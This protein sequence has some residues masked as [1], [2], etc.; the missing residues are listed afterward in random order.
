L[1]LVALLA[2]AAALSGALAKGSFLGRL[3][4]LLALLGLAAVAAW[5]AE[6]WA[7]GS[8]GERWAAGLLLGLLALTATRAGLLA[9]FD[10]LLG[11]RLGVAVPRLTRD[12]V[13]GVVYLLVVLLALQLATGT[14]LR[15]FLAASAVVTLILGLALQ[16]TLGTLIAGLTLLGDRPLTTGTWVE[17]DGLLG[18]LEEL[19]WRALV[20][21]TRT[22][23]RVLVPN[24]QV[25]RSSL[26]V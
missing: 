14:D 12:V 17:M 26:Q 23:Q 8:L 10:F 22:G 16:E 11:R 13:S 7:S 5:G 6:S 20:V 18:Q 2:F 21:R 24:Y 15:A 9:I 1:F 4:G 19:T 25:A 3:R